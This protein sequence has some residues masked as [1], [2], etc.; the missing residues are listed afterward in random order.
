M[1]SGANKFKTRGGNAGIEWRRKKWTTMQSVNYV[2]KTG[3]R[4]N[5]KDTKVV[6]SHYVNVQTFCACFVLLTPA[7][8]L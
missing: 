1:S 4:E 5:R 2:Q 6:M 7:R 3:F 8:I